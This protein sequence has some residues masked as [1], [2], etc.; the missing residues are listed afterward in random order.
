MWYLCALPINRGP[1]IPSWH[2]LDISDPAK[3]DE[4]RKK[5][6]ELYESDKFYY[7]GHRHYYEKGK[8]ILTLVWEENIR[9]CENILDETES[10]WRNR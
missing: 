8:I 10:G 6:R 3:V 5:A 2:I 7:D 9:T 1:A 4:A